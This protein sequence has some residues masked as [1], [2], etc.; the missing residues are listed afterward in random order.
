MDRIVSPMVNPYDDSYPQSPSPLKP[1]GLL[2]GEGRR[3][4]TEDGPHRFP[5]ASRSS[6]ALHRGPR[7]R[8]STT[9][10]S[11]LPTIPS[12][13][14]AAYTSTDVPQPGRLAVPRIKRSE[15]F[16]SPNWNGLGHSL[17]RAPSF[18]TL[19]TRSSKSHDSSRMSVDDQKENSPQTH[20]ELDIYPSS[21]DEEKLRS[22]KVKKLKT[23]VEASPTID[24]GKR[25]RSSSRL[26]LP[27]AASSATLKSSATTT[28][29]STVRSKKS[30]RAKVPKASTIFGAELPHPQ[31]EPSPP[32]NMPSPAAPV[33]LENL[34]TP[35]PGR[36]LRRV[37]TTNFPSQMS[38]RIS[39]SNLAPPVE[40]ESTG[41]GSGLG[42]AFEM[43]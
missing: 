42:S 32:A 22:K 38:R 3:T 9:T 12:E 2:H 21:D 14:A 27:K 4:P 17:K 15:S 19:S 28:P 24:K 18:G 20:Q 11:C 7:L 26:T 31:P 40:E 16:S 36:T 1:Y 39:F 34:Q 6:I 29:T 23:A 37:K 5:S 35:A 13:M 41:Q 8:R 43:Q 30:S 25:T 33:I 10:V